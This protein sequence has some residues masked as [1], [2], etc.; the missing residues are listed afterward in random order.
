MSF[1]AMAWAI[2]QKAP[3]KPKFLLL[4]LANYAD[5]NGVCFP[6][7]KRLVDDTGIPKSTLVLCLAKLTKMGFISKNRKYPKKFNN[8]NQYTLNMDPTSG[9][10]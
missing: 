4:V 8:S 2:R 10:I 9:P 7:I 1:Q 5:E 3:T 6:S